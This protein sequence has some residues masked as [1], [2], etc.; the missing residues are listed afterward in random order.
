MN[1]SGHDPRGAGCLDK[2]HPMSLTP[3]GAA[4]M[5]LTAAL[6]A[7]APAALKAQASCARSCDAYEIGVPHADMETCPEAMDRDGT[8]CR[9]GLVA[10]VAT[11]FTFSEADGCLVDTRAFFEDEYLLSFR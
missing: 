4:M 11:V 3:Y 6:A 5:A 10:E 7:L 2:E 8:C 9:L 1:F